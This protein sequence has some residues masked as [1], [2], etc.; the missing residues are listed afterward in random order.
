MI[1]SGH[2][3]TLVRRGETRILALFRQK[4]ITVKTGASEEGKEV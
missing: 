1:S 2:Q 4:N 3:K